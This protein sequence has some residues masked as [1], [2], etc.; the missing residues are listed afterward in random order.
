MTVSSSNHPLSVTNVRALVNRLM[1]TL[2]WYRIS[3][4]SLTR[5]LPAINCSTNKGRF[6]SKATHRSL[7]DLFRASSRGEIYKPQ[8]GKRFGNEDK[9]TLS[10]SGSTEFLSAEK[11]ILLGKSC[12]RTMRIFCV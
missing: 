11:I 5:R 10:D 2:G 8:R 7:V 3:G 12:E 9:N 4:S 6:L 1:Q